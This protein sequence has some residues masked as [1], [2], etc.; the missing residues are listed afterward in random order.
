MQEK[1][2]SISKQIGEYTLE[3]HKRGEGQTFGIEYQI[4]KNGELF[5]ALPATVK[6]G[7]AKFGNLEEIET[8]KR[9]ETIK[10]LRLLFD[11]MDTTLPKIGVTHAKG[12]V[13]TQIWRL[14][15]QKGA[16]ATP[17]NLKLMDVSK[18]Y[19]RRR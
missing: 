15:K 5:F 3:I 6:N 9:T 4:S 2:I 12:T 13:H 19:P 7:E 17:Y 10:Q 11:F 8:Q 16:I 1:R 14:M 18:R